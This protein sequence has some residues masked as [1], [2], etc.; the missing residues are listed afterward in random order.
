MGVGVTI[1]ITI[2]YACQGFPHGTIDK[3]TARKGQ[4]LF[5]KG[6]E[7]CNRVTFT[8]KATTDIDRDDFKLTYVRIFL[9]KF[10]YFFF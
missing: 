4:A 6:F 8:K 3:H 10:F 7:F 9:A 1:V 5:A 2:E